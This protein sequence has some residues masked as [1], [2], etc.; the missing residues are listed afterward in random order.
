MKNLIVPINVQAIRVSPD[1]ASYNT[2][3]FAGATVDFKNLPVR[4]EDDHEDKVKR[5]N[6]SSEIVNG[7]N[8]GTDWPLPAGVHLHWLLP[9]AL[10][11]GYEKDGH[12]HFPPAPN[13]WLITRTLVSADGEQVLTKQWVLVSDRVMDADEYSAYLDQTGRHSVSI[14]V[15]WK[16]TE[17]LLNNEETFFELPYKRMGR[18]FELEEWEQQKLAPSPPPEPLT[19]IGS[20]GPGF[21]AYY[22][23]CSSVFGFHDSFEDAPEEIVSPRGSGSDHLLYGAQFSVSYQISGWHNEAGDDPLQA[24]PFKTELKK[25]QEHNRKTQRSQRLDSATLFA[26]TAWQTH[27][28]SI[29]FTK[30]GDSPDRCYYAGQV[31]ALPWDTRDLNQ[32]FLKPPGVDE[33]THVAVGTT[34]TEALAAM[35][36]NDWAKKFEKRPEPATEHNLELLIDALQIGLLDRIGDSATLTQLVSELHQSG[37]G[38]AGGGL[39]WR[40]RNRPSEEGSRIEES[41]Q[42]TLPDNDGYSLKLLRDEN[43]EAPTKGKHEVV[44]LQ[45]KAGV[46]IVVFDPNGAKIAER[47]FQQ[48]PDELEQLLAV[49]EGLDVPPRLEHAIAGA[50]LKLANVPI[51]DLARLLGELNRLQQ[52]FDSIEDAI[53]S[54]RKQ[55]FLD[56]R[57]FLGAT[58][59]DASTLKDHM[60]NLVD[61]ISRQIIG[62]RANMSATRGIRE[63]AIRDGDKLPK[64]HSGK[65]VW[66]EQLKRWETDSAPHNEVTPIAR[67]IADRANELV[68]ILGEKFERFELTNVPAPRFWEPQEPV[69]AVSAQS[70]KPA[71]RNGDGGRLPCRLEENVV[72]ILKL[73]DVVLTLA[74][75]EKIGGLVL[76]AGVP[77]G[78]PLGVLL[79]ES[80]LFDPSLAAR[81]QPTRA[82]TIS[83]RLSQL[84]EEIGS[85]WNA[86]PSAAS[87]P[88]WLPGEAMDPKQPPPVAEQPLLARIGVSVT[89][90]LPRGLAITW[91]AEDD[92]EDRFLPLQLAWRAAIKPVKRR[93]K[94]D[95][96][97]KGALANQFQLGEY[98]VDLQV[99]AKTPPELVAGELQLNGS[100]PLSASVAMPIVGRILAYLRENPAAPN[101]EILENVAR[102][103]QDRPFLSQALGGINAEFLSRRRG[104]QLRPFD[105]H[106]ILEF[107]KP[108]KLG[109]GASARHRHNYANYLTY[110]VNDAIEGIADLEPGEHYA[111]LRSGTLDLLRLTVIDCFGRKQRLLPRKRSKARALVSPAWR[112]RPNPELTETLGEHQVFLPPRLAQAARLRFRW[113]S[114]TSNRVELNDHPATSPI[115]GWVVPNLLDNSLLLFHSDGTQLGSIGVFGGQSNVSTRPAPG[116][117]FEQFEN[118]LNNPQLT[119]AHFRRFILFALGSKQSRRPRRFFQQLLKAILRAQA[120]SLPAN[121]DAAE[122][123]VMLTGRPLAITRAGLRLETLGTPACDSTVAG[124]L[125]DLGYEYGKKDYSPFDW[126]KRQHRGLLDVDF[127]VRL[128]NRSEIE[129]GLIGYMLDEV[130]TLYAPGLAE[131]GDK[132]IRR[133]DARPIRLTL[134]SSVDPPDLPY[135][136]E[137]QQLQDLLRLDRARE[138]T[139]LTLLVDPLAQVHATT[140]V[141]P[142]RRLGLPQDQFAKAL[143][144]IRMSF[145]ASPVLKPA[146][147]QRLPLSEPPALSWTFVEAEKISEDRSRPLVEE[148]EPDVVGDRAQFNYTPQQIREGWL[149]LDPARENGEEEP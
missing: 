32:Q 100:I 116:R 106:Y 30:D 56:W 73:G 14:P 3:K 75:A 146:S 79:A 84:L 131:A 109:A 108:N 51:S 64:F 70:L 91:R 86:G 141:L 82:G 42:A 134:K 37:F 15:D 61:M 85:C 57:H 145:F 49:I 92:W 69:L 28:W 98:G 103:L 78:A 34:G 132:N 121:P 115:C 36:S 74:D 5:A 33:S 58:F 71:R 87:N 97:K 66:N 117:Q 130:E 43:G 125:K 18:V 17:P 107:P 95:L 48:L 16:P 120:H 53:E 52:R 122:A 99:D 136:S 138:W 93:G 24:E 89:G 39:V 111:P 94:N 4:R 19:A 80:R 128:G 147:G 81:I 126:T 23:D 114:A 139:Q 129:D 62:L 90:V 7:P 50:A 22:P 46:E 13:R 27:R 1:D 29:P 143:E 68:K 123:T 25:A 26:R 113:I 77:D 144:T 40:I 104:L 21:A 11:R 83:K 38:S 41:P 2:N 12:L 148:L 133:P 55:I 110:F 137:D 47:E 63:E 142:V 59:S 105:P 88:V 135:E 101:R 118:D 140:G 10:S 31:A 35:L 60:K 72:K 20:S 9:D 44:V 45:K 67:Q 6:L 76:N 96:Y 112:L 65:I 119:N 149:R 127:P 102:Y 54:S 8:A 124:L